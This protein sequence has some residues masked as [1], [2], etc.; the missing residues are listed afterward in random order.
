M[1]VLD[2]YSQNPITLLSLDVKVLRRSFLKVSNLYNLQI[3]YSV[4]VSSILI[5]FNASDS[6]HLEQNS[7]DLSLSA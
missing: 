4:G 7:F 3:P 6:A 1:I 2:F 5:P